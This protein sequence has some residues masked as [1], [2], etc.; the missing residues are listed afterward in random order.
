MA[1]TVSN[2]GKVAPQKKITQLGNLAY[3][4]PVIAKDT[5]TIRDLSATVSEVNFQLPLTICRKYVVGHYEDDNGVM[6]A[7]IML[8]TKEKTGKNKGRPT[9]VGLVNIPIDLFKKMYG[10]PKRESISGYKKLQLNLKKLPP[11]F[12]VLDKNGLVIKP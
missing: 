11:F 10:I 4:E 7:R 2:I 5:I 1:K 3:L 12:D 6:L 9:L 8:I